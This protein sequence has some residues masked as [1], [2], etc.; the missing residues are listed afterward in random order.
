VIGERRAQPTADLVTVV[1][2]VAAAVV[3]LGWLVVRGTLSATASTR[4]SLV[5]YAARPDAVATPAGLMVVGPDGRIAVVSSE[6]QEAVV[7]VTVTV[8]NVCTDQARLVDF[9]TSLG[10]AP[11]SSSTFTVSDV[12]LPPLGRTTIDLRTHGAPCMLPAGAPPGTMVRVDSVTVEQL[13]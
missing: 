9:G 8:T 7:Q 5:A 4:P 13:P 1:V 6:P 10:L 12:E 3:L 11:G 2:T